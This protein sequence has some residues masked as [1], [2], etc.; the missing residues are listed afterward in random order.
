[1]KARHFILLILTSQCFG[2]TEQHSQAASGVTDSGPLTLPFQR[3]SDSTPTSFTDSPHN[4]FQEHSLSVTVCKDLNAVPHSLQCA[5]VHKYC[6][7]DEFNIGI[8]NYLAIYACYLP[9]ALSIAA[10]LI[11]ISVSFAGLGKTAADFLSPNLYTISKVLKL[12]D[13]LAGL[14]LLALGNSAADIFGTYKALSI[15]SAELAISELIG[16]TLFVLTVVVGSIC[17]VRPFPVPKFHYARDNASYLIVLAVIEGALENGA[18]YMFGA[19]CLM[20]LYVIYVMVALLNHSWLKI[21]NRKKLT[22]ARVRSNFDVLSRTFLDGGNDMDGVPRRPGID[23]LEDITEEE[24]KMLDELE[25]YFTAHPEDEV[26]V[27][28]PVQT[29]SY[30]LRILLKELR[31]HSSHQEN[32][33]SNYFANDSSSME[34]DESLSHLADDSRGLIPAREIRSTVRDEQDRSSTTP[35]STIER[36]LSTRSSIVREVLHSLRPRWNPADSTLHKLLFV[37]SYPASIALAFTTPVR[38]KALT[39]AKI[40]VRGSNAFTLTVPSQES[41]AITEED[42]DIRLD[43]LAFKLQFTLCITTLSVMY[44]KSH[45]LSF[46]LLPFIFIC[47]SMISII[48]LPSRCPQFEDQMSIFKAWNYVGSVLGFILSV[49]WITVFATEVIAVLK[50]FALILDLSDEI[51]GVTVFA[52]GNSIGDLIS[53]LTIALMGM[54]LMAFAACFGGPLLSL[55]SMGASSLILMSRNDIESIAIINSMTLRLNI[56][57]IFSVLVLMS[58][59]FSLR[60]HYVADRQL[61]VCLILI[62]VITVVSSAYLELT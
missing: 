4:L 8:L 27:P 20:V 45:Y 10:A 19:S 38:E 11:S 43:L 53:N 40:V 26:E 15:G 56:I 2:S 33:I 57:V 21:H 44:L 17:I 55:C 31:H 18:L 59:Y 61:G 47:S 62:W 52:M 13:H 29:G 39:H 16:A 30:G 48:F 14:T 50:Q 12:S 25:D 1:M 51:L 60:S 34:R 3:I 32:R 58:V 41:L 5:H 46:I 7:T 54:P 42:Y 22:A 36:S 23:S 37:I 24:R 49:H 35:S 9:K 28:V 6:N